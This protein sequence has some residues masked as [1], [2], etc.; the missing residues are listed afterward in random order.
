[1]WGCDPNC[2]HVWEDATITDARHLPEDEPSPKQ[3]TNTGSHQRGVKPA[4]ICRLCGSWRGILGLE[5]T[6]E[7]YL[8]HLVEV[9]REVRR[10]LR[11]DGT[12]WLNIGDSYASNGPSGGGS[13]VDK[14]KPEYGRIGS[15][16]DVSKGRK[17]I[18]Y[19]GLP[20]GV[21]P[22][23]LLMIP[24]QLAL[25]LRA[26][27]WYL[28]SEIVWT[29]RAPMPES[30][31]GS[32]F[33]RHRITISEHER[34][35]DLRHAANGTDRQGVDCPG[36]QICASNGGY[37]LRISAGR[38]TCA[39]EKVFLLTKSAKYFFDNEAVKEESEIPDRDHRRESVA[40]GGFGGKTA[41]TDKPA[42]RA[43]T[44]TRN[45]R[46]VWHLAPEPFPEAHFATYPSEIPRRAIS[47]GTSAKGVCPKCA[48]PWVRVVERKDHGITTSPV[49]AVAASG[50]V[51]SGGVDRCRLGHGG[52]FVGEMVTIGWRPSCSCEQSR[53]PKCATVVDHR[54]GGEEIV[55]VA[56][57]SDV[58]DTIPAVEA[59]RQLLQ[60]GMLS[61]PG[62]PSS[63][64]PVRR[65]R[66]DLSSED[67][68]LSLLQPG[69]QQ[70]SGSSAARIDERLDNHNKGLSVR[71]PAR[72]SESDT[73]WL[74]DGTSACDGEQ[75]EAAS[76]GRR[77]CSSQ[78][79]RSARQSTREPRS[80]GE[81]GT[82]R[83]SK[84]SL[85][86]RLSALPQKF[87]SKRQ[88]SHCGSSLERAT[89]APIPS[90]ILDC[91][92]GSGTTALVA[93]QL[94][95]DCIGIELNAKYAEMAER[96][97]RDDAGMFADLAAE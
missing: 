50:G 23:D 15:P 87:S 97:I 79:R 53:C 81:D 65:V 13:P 4:D 5:P 51:Q 7:L 55:T 52:K 22:K 68:Q 74:R 92:L 48:A 94:G 39:H 19:L 12:L 10:V 76:D 61:E 17:D 75:A 46:N 24:A 57:V 43:V 14:R 40:K 95:R 25:A 38:P 80:D 54:H 49:Y 63:G 90:T 3:A 45:L 47:A 18:R 60:P 32:R 84:A 91:F 44:Q 9:F 21:K 41:G 59:G 34:L 85:S 71:S 8:A 93:D 27:G 83:A 11:K 42:F 66:D 78:E 88:C 28:R 86:R 58:R 62:T 67:G 72:P 31:N 37:I 33:E 2:S 36:C 30:V 64:P 73:G 20:T 89:Y 16:G 29:K 70:S 1:V 26:D 69:M 96:R 77:G 56:P 35:S 6:V 82:R